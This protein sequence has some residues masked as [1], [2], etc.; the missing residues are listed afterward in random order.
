MSSSAIGEFRSHSF[1]ITYSLQSHEHSHDYAH[2]HA[3]DDKHQFQHDISNHNHSYDGA[4]LRTIGL[5]IFLHT[6]VSES[7]DPPLGKPTYQPFRLER[8]PRALFIA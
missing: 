6:R 7:F 3:V 1:S 4:T 5:A 8:P 2:F